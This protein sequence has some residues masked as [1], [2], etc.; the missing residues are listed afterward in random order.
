MKVLNDRMVPSHDLAF[1]I[2]AKKI[3]EEKSITKGKGSDKRSFKPRVA[4]LFAMGGSDW[5]TLALP[6]LQIFALPMNMTVVDQQLF[7]LVVLS[8]GAFSTTMLP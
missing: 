2:I 4:S 8:T 6:M 7:I 3:R 5:T 1:R